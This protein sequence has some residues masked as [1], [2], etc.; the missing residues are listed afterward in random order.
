MARMDLH[1]DPVGMRCS[2]DKRLGALHVREVQSFEF[3][4]QSR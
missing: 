2:A 4:A 1:T 3:K